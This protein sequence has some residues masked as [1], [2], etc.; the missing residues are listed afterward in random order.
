VSGE[1]L[2]P[3]YLLTGTDRPKVR[4]ALGRLRA[5]FDPGSVEQLSA[6]KVPDR[7]AVSGREAVETCNALGLFGGEESRLVVVERVERWK[8]ADVDAVAGYL[9]DPAPATVLAL[10]AEEPAKNKLPEICAEFGDVLEYDVPRPRDLP[11][12]VREH[13]ARRDTRAVGD[14][15]QALVEIVGDDPVALEAEVDK[16]ATWAAGDEIERSDVESLAAPARDESAW[17]VTDAWGNR[18]LPLL[19]ESA[20]RTLEHEKPFVVALRL[21]GHVARVRAVQDLAA[22]GQPAGA[23][24]KRL[25]IHEFPARKAMA[26]AQNYSREELDSAVVRLSALDANLKGASRL[27]AELELERA[28]VDVTAGRTA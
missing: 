20:E 13:F 7:E 21:A 10:I 14:A 6:E 25:R 19:L 9:T 17:A 28:L 5:R 4:R 2:R 8:A 26:H 3:V 15:A 1:R 11:A 16:I 12:W 23:I 24:A 27:S 18:D 22:E